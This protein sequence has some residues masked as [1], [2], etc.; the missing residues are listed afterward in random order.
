MI[1]RDELKNE[2]VT[3]R[4]NSIKRLGTIARALGE[5]RTRNELLPFLTDS[6]DDDDE[7]LLVLAEQLGEF[8]PYV[9]KSGG[10]DGVRA[11]GQNGPL[12]LDH[13]GPNISLPW[14]RPR[15]VASSCKHITI[16]SWSCIS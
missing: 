7:A 8:L 6:N 10:S 13:T 14:P 1:N 11:L 15:Q 12:E 2:D 3:L 5:E 4:I 9:G 16:R